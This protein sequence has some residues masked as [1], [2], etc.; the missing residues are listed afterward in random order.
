[1][2]KLSKCPL[3]D[4]WAKKVGICIEWNISQ[5]FLNGN[6]A[7]YDNMNEPGGHYIKWNQSNSE[8]NTA[9]S[10]SYVESKKKSDS[11]K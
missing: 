6:S 2:G 4:E 7:I 10:H 8:R 11:E 9:W 5:I 3:K 1:M